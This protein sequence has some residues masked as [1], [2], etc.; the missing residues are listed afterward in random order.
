[1]GLLGEMTVK[2]NGDV[3]GLAQAGQQASGILSNLASG[4]F[5]GA[6]TDGFQMVGEAAAGFAASSVSAAADFQQSMLKVQAYAG[7]TQKQADDMANSIMQMSGQVGQAPK[8]LADAIYPIVSSGYAASD[9]LNI[10]KLSAESSAASGAQ[11][12]V[13]A[14]ALTTS[15]KAM[16]AP[17]SQAGLYMDMLNKTVSLGKGELPQYSAGVGK[18]SVQRYGC[19]PCNPHNAR[20]SLRRTS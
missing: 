3:S 19:R 11:T 8:E 13:V 2:I 14:D 17:A 15:L 6:L 5:A 9:A 18:Y 4:N 16:H 10:L 7:L 12:S 1:M 20:F